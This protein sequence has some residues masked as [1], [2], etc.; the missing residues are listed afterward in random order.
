MSMKTSPTIYEHMQAAVDIVGDSPHPTNKIAATIAG[1]GWSIS[2]TNHWPKIIED[3]IGREPD[4]G[5]SSGTIHAETACILNAPQATKGASLFITDPPCPNCMKN[6]AE[7]GIANL[8]IDHK[9]FDK[10]WAK[11]RGD[12]FQTMSMR[13]AAKAGMNVHVI[14]RKEEKFE[15]ISRHPPGYKPNEENP[16][17]IKPTTMPSFGS[18]EGSYDERA[19]ASVKPKDDSLWKDILT[20]AKKS[21]SEEPFA[22]ALAADQNGETVSILVDRHPTIGYTYETVENKE[23]KYSFIL[24]P[25]NR[26]LMIAAKEGLTLDPDHIYSSRTPTS[27][28]FVNFIG[29]GFTTLQIGNKEKA[30]DEHGLDAL[31]QLTNSKILHTE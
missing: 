8:Y 25:I 2:K 14:Y 12:S 23:D 1:D 7:A 3:N 13:V 15:I 30:R 31:N 4:I 5:N 11:R 20:T 19:D 16:A 26:L 22:L 6:M 18:T 28:E 17:I 21:H 27:R 9:G 24:Q 10:D 29:A